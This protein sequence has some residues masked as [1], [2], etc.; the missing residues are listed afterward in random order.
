VPSK[1]AVGIKLIMYLYLQVRTQNFC[2]GAEPGAIYNL[3]LILKIV[4]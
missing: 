1:V 3:C 4:L 2:S